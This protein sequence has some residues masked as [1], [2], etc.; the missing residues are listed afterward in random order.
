VKKPHDG[1]HGHKRRYTVILCTRK[2]RVPLFVSVFSVVALF[3][4]TDLQ[5]QIRYAAGQN[6]V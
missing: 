5:A 3:A 6:V 1:G 4:A 2:N